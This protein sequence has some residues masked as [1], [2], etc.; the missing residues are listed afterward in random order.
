MYNFLRDLRYGVRMPLRSQPMGRSIS[1]PLGRAGAAVLHQQSENRR[2]TVW[3]EAA[4]LSATY[5]EV[6]QR[7]QRFERPIWNHFERAHTRSMIGGRDNFQ[8]LFRRVLLVRNSF[9]V[10]QFVPSVTEYQEVI[11]PCGF[12]DEPLKYFAL[13]IFVVS[14]VGVADFR[15][16]F[17]DDHANEVY[18]VRFRIALDIKVDKHGAVRE[19]RSSKDIYFL[20][21]DC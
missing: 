7:R 13:L 5:Q 19:F 21:S 2:T 8:V 3:G 14:P 10:G 15:T 20:I 9:E 18:E 16:V 12:S 4:T 11:V 17:H 6:A 1:V